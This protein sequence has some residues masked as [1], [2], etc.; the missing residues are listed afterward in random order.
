[1]A[2]FLCS[3]NTYRVL[4]GPYH[5]GGAPKR[6]ALP[7]VFSRQKDILARRLEEPAFASGIMMAGLGSFYAWSVLLRP[8]GE[9]VGVGAQL[10]ARC[11]KPSELRR[12]PYR[13]S[14]QNSSTRHFGE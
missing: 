4:V 1:M 14:S 9:S 10:M 6:R 2:S 13:R 8:S 12:T 11:P 5:G 3:S 7:R